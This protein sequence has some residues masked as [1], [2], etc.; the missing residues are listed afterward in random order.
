MVVMIGT[1]TQIRVVSS[2][3]EDLAGCQWEVH[4][5]PCPLWRELDSAA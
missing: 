5:A 1:L 3:N 2:S 4:G